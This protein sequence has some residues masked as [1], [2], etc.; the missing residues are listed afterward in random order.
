VQAFLDASL[1]GWDYALDHPQEMIDLIYTQYSQRHSR[2]HLA[3]EAAKTEPLILP[4]VVEIGYM[5]SGRWQHIADT[6]ATMGLAPGNISLDGF[7][8]DRYPNPNL[9]WIYGALLTT[10]IVLGGISA[11]AARFYKLNMVIRQE[12]LEKEAI[13]EHLRTLEQRYRILVE[14]APL[15]HCH[16]PSKRWLYPVC[17]L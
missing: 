11:I 16:F 1:K 6:Y 3:F 4:D 8:Y 7:L 9:T 14:N 10:L 15:C 2:E 17:E 5:N 12:M 13:T